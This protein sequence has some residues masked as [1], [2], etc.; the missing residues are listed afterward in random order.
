MALV[1]VYGAAGNYQSEIYYR[2]GR[3]EARK[4][5]TL[6]GGWTVTRIEPHRV[7]VKGPHN[8]HGEIAFKSP[9]IIRRELGLDSSGAT[10]SNPAAPISAPPSLSQIK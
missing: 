8:Q 7:L 6:P 4:H 10:N 1:S 9:E 5:D 3:I 2:G